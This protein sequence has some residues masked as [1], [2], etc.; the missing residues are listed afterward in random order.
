M[1][2]VTDMT[3]H[4]LTIKTSVVHIIDIKYKVFSSPL[5]HLKTLY[6]FLAF[7]ER[8]THKTHPY[9]HYQSYLHKKLS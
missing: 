7:I 1:T 5:G 4:V 2:Y 8:I 6:V 3:S 9:Y